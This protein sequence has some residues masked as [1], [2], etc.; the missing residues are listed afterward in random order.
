MDRHKLAQQIREWNANRLDLFELSEP[1]EVLLSNLKHYFN[2][3]LKLFCYWNCL[4]VE[5]WI[6]KLLKVSHVTI[7]YKKSY[8]LT[9][10]WPSVITSG[11][12]QDTIG[13]CANTSSR[14]T[15]YIIMVPYPS[16]CCHQAAD[17]SPIEIALARN[18]LQSC[19]GNRPNY[20]PKLFYYVQAIGSWIYSSVNTSSM[21]LACK[22]PSKWN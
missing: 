12:F 21:K 2:I 9:N 3:V 11:V 18:Q 1:N 20:G 15:A 13:V 7:F 16:E 4:I 22:P 19:W 8:Y 17:M 14:L 6:V 10:V 5:S